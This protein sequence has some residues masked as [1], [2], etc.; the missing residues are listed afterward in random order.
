MF[1]KK[2][3]GQRDLCLMHVQTLAD[4][5]KIRRKRYYYNRIGTRHRKTRERVFKQ[6]DI[7]SVKRNKNLSESLEQKK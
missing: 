2:F 5:V 7:F 1:D 3:I 4:R 6:S